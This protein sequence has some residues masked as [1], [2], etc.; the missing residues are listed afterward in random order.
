MLGSEAATLGGP[1]TPPPDS[2]TKRLRSQTPAPCGFFSRLCRPPSSSVLHA[3]GHRET[4][5]RG[6]AASRG[7]T[8]RLFFYVPGHP[9][10]EQS[11]HSS[12]FYVMTNPLPRTHVCFNHSPRALTCGEGTCMC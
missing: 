9:S 12:E 11:A 5:P 3:R 6:S 2:N 10:K 1:Q 8:P 4:R 7:L